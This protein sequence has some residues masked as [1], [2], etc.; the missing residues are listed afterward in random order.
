M[1]CAVEDFSQNA[2]LSLHQ[3]MLN[4]FDKDINWLKTIQ[5]YLD[6]EFFK[7]RLKDEDWQIV[8]QLFLNTEIE[9]LHYIKL[10]HDFFFGQRD[11]QEAALLEIV[12]NPWLNTDHCPTASTLQAWSLV[13]TTDTEL[14]EAAKLMSY[15]A[16]RKRNAPHP[17]LPPQ[18]QLFQTVGYYEK[19]S[20][21]NRITEGIMP[22][23][24]LKERVQQLDPVE[25]ANL[26]LDALTTMSYKGTEKVHLRSDSFL[27]AGLK[28][29]DPYVALREW[30]PRRAKD[31]ENAEALGVS[32]ADA[33]RVLAS[34]TR[35]TPAVQLPNSIAI[36]IGLG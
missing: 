8:A 19:H 23:A 3:S 5:P 13:E 28:T 17:D 27:V 21:G 30:I 6:L 9:D 25:A 15:A 18:A 20:M 4:Y 32:A 24:T 31:F 12:E 1:W 14:Y 29:D 36:D 22:V 35:T 7:P 26:L 10:Q 33:C 2:S 34:E 11:A 16:G